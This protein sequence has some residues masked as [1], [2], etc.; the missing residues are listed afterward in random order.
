MKT[1]SR[2]VSKAR[3]LSI[4]ITSF[5]MLLLMSVTNAFAVSFDY[6]ANGQKKV[7]QLGLPSYGLS[8]AKCCN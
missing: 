8:K 3:S 7:Q 2:H 4:S 5:L 1:E 6:R